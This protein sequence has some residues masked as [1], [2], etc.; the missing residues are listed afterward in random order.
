MD[1]LLLR[2][3]EEQIGHESFLIGVVLRPECDAELLDVKEP[4]ELGRLSGSRK[5]FNVCPFPGVVPCMPCCPPIRIKSRARSARFSRESLSC[6]FRQ[7]FEAFDAASSH[8]ACAKKI[9]HLPWE[10]KSNLSLQLL[11]RDQSPTGW[12]VQQL[13][14]QEKKL[15][16]PAQSHFVTSCDC[17]VRLRQSDSHATQLEN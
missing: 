16:S 7:R 9:S 17:M 15:P 13:G 10:K 6:L 12:F 5:E 8:C 11:L 14:Q 4:L 1:L 3:A 2:R